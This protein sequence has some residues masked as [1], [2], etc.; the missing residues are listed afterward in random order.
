M[1]KIQKEPVR[2]LLKEKYYCGFV[3]GAQTEIGQNQI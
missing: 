1:K 2:R 3:G